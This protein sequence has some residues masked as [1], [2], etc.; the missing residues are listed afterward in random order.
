MSEPLSWLEWVPELE[1]P[2]PTSVV[3][4]A[5]EVDFIVREKSAMER[6]IR[7]GWQVIEGEKER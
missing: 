4:E 3:N 5:Y 1:R 6:A 7:R 2:V